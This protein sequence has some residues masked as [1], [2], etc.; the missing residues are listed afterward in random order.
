WAAGDRFEDVRNKAATA[1]RARRTRRT[2]AAAIGVPITG[3][4]RPAE[5]LSPEPRQESA[6]SRATREPERRAPLVGGL[7]LLHNR[8]RDAA[9]LADRQALSPGPLADLGRLLA[10]Q[11]TRAGPAPA[12]APLGLDRACLVDEGRQSLAQRFLVLLGKINLIVDAVE[13]ELDDVLGLHLGAVEVVNVNLA[14][15]LSHAQLHTHRVHV[16]CSGLQ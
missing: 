11:R 12:P 9:A 10:A 5:D 7:V 15:Q 4:R 6:A 3:V 14:N 16:Y 1:A 13:A 2:G 8:G